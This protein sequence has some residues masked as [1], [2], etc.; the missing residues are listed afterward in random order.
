MKNISNSY[1][2][3]IMPLTFICSGRSVIL[4]HIRAGKELLSQLSATGLI[5]G[6]TVNMLRNDYKGP[7]ILDVGGGRLMLGRGMAEKVAVSTR[8]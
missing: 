2:T 4:S 1:S 8:P 5:P 7:V 3:S 6:I